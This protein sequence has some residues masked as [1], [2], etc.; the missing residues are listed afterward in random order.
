M[1]TEAFTQISRPAKGAPPVVTTGVR[2]AFDLAAPVVNAQKERQGTQF[3]VLKALTDIGGVVSADVLR[4]LLSVHMS[5]KA[6]FQDVYNAKKLNRLRK[7]GDG[8]EVTQAGKEFL[9]TQ[10]NTTEA[11]AKFAPRRP[12]QSKVADAPAQLIQPAAVG[13]EGARWALWS[14]GS[15]VL[16][17]GPVCIELSI[18]EFAALRS[19]IEGHA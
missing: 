6:I 10:C 19:A 2:S 7:V 14:D 11:D 17:R 13:S 16:Q 18:K 15:F 4:D 9:Q 12:A 8:Y 3:L 1:T 5:P